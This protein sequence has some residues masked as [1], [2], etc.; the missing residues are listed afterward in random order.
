MDCIFHIHFT[1][2]SN[3]WQP[4]VYVC[5]IVF[6]WRLSNIVTTIC[7]G[8]TAHRIWFSSIDPSKR[9]EQISICSYYSMAFSLLTKKPSQ[10]SV[11]L[12]T[13]NRN[14]LSSIQGKLAVGSHVERE[15][16]FLPKTIHSPFSIF[17]LSC[18]PS[19]QRGTPEFCEVRRINYKFT[20]IY[21][22]LKIRREL[23]FYEYIFIDLLKSINIQ[24]RDPTIIKRWWKIQ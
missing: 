19:R 4:V 9:P 16:L 13:E 14:W 21:W 3:P 1:D 12:L 18:S 8:W 7:W 5:E 23:S 2:W 22:L 20:T 10:R 6:R 15:Q 17:L 11:L 24:I